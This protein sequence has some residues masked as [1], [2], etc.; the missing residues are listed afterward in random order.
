[1][2]SSPTAEA[3]IQIVPA[4]EPGESDLLI[5]WQQAFPFRL[6]LAANDGGSKSTGKHLGSVTVSGDYAFISDFGFIAPYA[7]DLLRVNAGPITALYGVD[8]I[9][10]NLSYSKSLTTGAIT[11]ALTVANGFFGE[12]SEED[13]QSGSSQGNEKFAYGLDVGF[14][15]PDEK[16]LVDAELVYDNDANPSGGDGLH[17]GLNGKFTPNPSLTVGAEFIYQ[18]LGAADNSALETQ[19]NLGL[20][21]LANYKLNPIMSATGMVQYVGIS[22]SGGVDGVDLSEVELSLALL[23]YPAGTEQLGL[24]FEV[25]YSKVETEVG[26]ATAKADTLG[27]AV[28]LLYIIP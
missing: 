18:S 12:A 27:A 19:T 6:T 24:N 20:M 8:Q 10:A 21:A 7:P 11:A 15:F 13:A 5:A 14:A 25:S 16:G 17:F 4:D 22:N 1:M 26:A 3:D 28:E 23:T 2:A 9:G